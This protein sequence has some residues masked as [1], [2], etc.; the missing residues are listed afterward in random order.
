MKP[1]TISITLVLSTLAVTSLAYGAT[2]PDRC[3]KLGT[4][5]YPKYCEPIGE[6]IAP[7]W[8]DPL[9][10]DGAECEPMGTA[11]CGGDRQ[12][13][14]CD[15]ARF[16][17]VG[18]VTCLFVV[19]H[20]CDEYSCEPSPVRDDQQPPQ[21][22][23]LCCYEEGCYAPDGG[24]CGGVLFWCDDGVSNSDGTVTCFDEDTPS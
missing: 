24:P 17:A 18:T 12:P 1:T 22:Q 20:Y 4:D 11:G 16:N 2:P 14:S 6:H 10:C 7:G 9:C 5:G 13:F 8:D 23:E 15:H 19:P 21:A 3:A